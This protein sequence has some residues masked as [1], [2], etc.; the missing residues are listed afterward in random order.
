[1]SDLIRVLIVDDHEVLAEGLQLALERQDGLAVVGTV[2]TVADARG[3]VE[4]DAVDVVVMDHHL[5]DGTGADAAQA[6]RGLRPGIAVVML[7]ADTSDDALLAAVS[8]GAAGYI[9]KT[10]TA[11]VIADA[12][13]RAAAGETLFAAD[14]LSRLLRL[15]ERPDP[16]VGPP[17]LTA[18]EME[19][20]RLVARGDDN[21]TIAN[22]LDIGVNTVRHHVQSILEK[23]DAHSKLQAVAHARA[24]GLLD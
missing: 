18:R 16:E 21:K 22:T 2:R 3:F 8:A 7:S 15:I 17:P 14:T 6:I 1:M 4:A 19:V 11:T 13:R 5:P 20:L 10:A 12:V 24:A 23:L 9:V